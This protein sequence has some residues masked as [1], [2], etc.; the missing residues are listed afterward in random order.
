MSEYYTLYTLY[1]ILHPLKACCNYRYLDPV[2]R[3]EI[4]SADVGGSR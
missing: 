4:T 1:V 3:W 2:D